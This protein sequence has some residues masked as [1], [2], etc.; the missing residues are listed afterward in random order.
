MTVDGYISHLTNSD[1]EL[2]LHGR[3]LAIIEVKAKKRPKWMS[4]GTDQVRRQEAAELSALAFEKYCSKARTE[5]KVDKGKEKAIGKF[6]VTVE[7]PVI[8]C[9]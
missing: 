9:C 5:E 3:I 8:T 4:D 2:L 6:F 7:R 1:E